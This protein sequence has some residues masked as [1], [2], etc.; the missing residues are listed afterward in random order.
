MGDSGILLDVSTLAS[1]AARVVFAVRIA[2]KSVDT[3][4]KR[5]S[6]AALMADLLI[7]VYSRPY[8]RPYRI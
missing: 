1:S 4:S 8:V 6:F 5:L 3:I 7:R 2:N